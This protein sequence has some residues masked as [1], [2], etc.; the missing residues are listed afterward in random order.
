MTNSKNLRCWTRK[1]KNNSTYVTCENRATRQMAT[2]KVTKQIPKIEVTK[3]PSQNKQ[4]IAG[5]GQMRRSARLA[6]KVFKYG[7]KSYKK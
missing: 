4:I 1:R 5:G 2:K 3:L 7:R 6:E